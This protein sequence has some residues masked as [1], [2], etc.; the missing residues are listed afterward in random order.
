M[1]LLIL[2]LVLAIAAPIGTTDPASAQSPTSYSWCSRG[3][4]SGPNNCYYASKEQCMRTI[5][6]IG[7]FCFPSPYYRQSAPGG[8]RGRQSPRR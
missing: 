7:A 1:R 5:S 6:A 4:R 2:S 8:S 3:T